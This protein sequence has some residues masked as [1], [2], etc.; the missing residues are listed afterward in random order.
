MD[1]E[2]DVIL[3]GFAAALRQAGLAITSDRTGA[4]WEAVA[5]VG[6]DR[7]RST[8]W[9]G[10]AT[11]CS[12]PEDVELYDKAFSAWFSPVADQPGARHNRPRPVTVPQASLVPPGSGT[13][14][15][16]DQLVA[17]RASAAETLRQRDIASLSAAERAQLANLFAGLDVR[18]PLRRA[19]RRRPHRR[20][21]VDLRRTLRQQLRTGE[22]TELRYRRRRTR[23]RRIVL[24]I[25][26]S[27]SMQPY[28]DALLRLA[29]R[30][31]NA[32]PLQVEVFTLGTRLTRVT[33]AMRARHAEE[34]LVQ[35]GRLVPD[36]SGGT[37]L[38]EVM[39]A[40]VGRWGR[41]GLARQA[42]VVVASDGWERGDPALLGEQMRQ[43]ALLSHAVI[44]MN[45]HRGKAGYAPIQG[46]I[47][48][49]LP[50]IDQLVA[51]HSLAAFA[52]LLGVMA[53]A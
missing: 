38:G 37:R 51:G 52:K 9:A 8:Y 23:P 36:W 31:T 46:G 15:L 53:D 44:W 42:V 35:A 33:A 21:R 28:A 22:V 19:F 20:G 45:P 1:T 49:S 27:G 14:E 41:R 25:D 40:F 3:T 43:L 30:I 18:T 34:A 39:A 29:H 13:G 7:Q 4:Y 50:W 32:D 2:A 16:Q 17:A 47:V 6:L 10:R 48:A 5:L 26:V 12:S 24:L 11:L